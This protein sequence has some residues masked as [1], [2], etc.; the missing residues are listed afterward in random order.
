MS[1]F[2]PSFNVM[3]CLRMIFLGGALAENPLINVDFKTDCFL[4]KGYSSYEPGNLR[5]L[6]VVL[7]GN[8]RSLISLILLLGPDFYVFI[9]QSEAQKYKHYT[10]LYANRLNASAFHSGFE[11]DT[12]HVFFSSVILHRLG[13]LKSFTKINHTFLLLV[14]VSIH[15]FFLQK[16][17]H[18][19]N[20]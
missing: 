11:M 17:A 2:I 20:V 10:S 19:Y 13:I 1:N 16:D 7:I 9:V 14:F 4:V 5:R 3:P 15:Y 8:S 12:D 6:S 18:K